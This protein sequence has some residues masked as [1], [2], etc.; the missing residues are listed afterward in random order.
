M[1][2]SNFEILIKFFA[3]KSS[4]IEYFPNFSNQ[5]IEDLKFSTE[6]FS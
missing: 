6:R 5:S 3:L 4:A 1:K 2:M